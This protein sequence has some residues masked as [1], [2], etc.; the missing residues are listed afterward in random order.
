MQWRASCIAT[1]LL[2]NRWHG[3][4]RVASVGLLLLFLLAIPY[5]FRI[6][7]NDSI[8]G[9]LGELSYPIYICHF[10]VIWTVSSLGTE[11]PALR[12]ALS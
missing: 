12:K 8:D 7:K 1:A 3:V 10:L 6:T 9:I 4:T 11:G 2:I 5:I